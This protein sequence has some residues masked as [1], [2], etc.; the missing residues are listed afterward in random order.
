VAGHLTSSHTPFAGAPT[1]F[2]QHSLFSSHSQVRHLS[3]TDAVEERFRTKK[4]PTS[5]TFGDQSFKKA[6]YRDSR[7]H[8]LNLACLEAF[9]A[10]A[11]ADVLPVNG[12]ADLLEVRAEDALIADM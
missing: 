11:H 4:P 12:G 2:K 3:L 8:A 6:E 7:D 5:W 9:G 1:S 10:H